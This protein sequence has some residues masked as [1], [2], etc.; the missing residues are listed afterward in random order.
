MQGE[1][2][3][4]LA[5]A[6]GSY[7]FHED[8]LKSALR[9]ANGLG[10][11][12][13]WQ[14][15]AEAVEKS[16]K[17]P[18]ATMASGPQLLVGN[19]MHRRLR[20]AENAFVYPVFY[21]Q[22]P[23]RDLDAGN[24]GIFSVDRANLLSLRQKDHGPRDGT[25]LLPWIQ[26][27]L[28]ERGLPDDGEITLQ[29]FPRVLGFVF[30]PVS[31]WFCRNTAGELI[32]VLA[33]V[34]NTFGGHHDYLL[35]NPDGS[36]LRDGQVL[37][38]GQ[39]VPRLAFLRRGRWL[40]L[41]FPCG[42]GPAAGLHRLRRRRGRPAADGDQRPARRLVEAGAARHL[43]AHAAADRRRHLAHPLA[44][45]EAVAEGRAVSWRAS[46]R[47]LP[48]PAGIDKMNNT[49]T[50]GGAAAPSRD[51]TPGLRAARRP[52]RRPARNPPAGRFQ[53]PVRR[54]R[55]GRHAACP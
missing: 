52:P 48:T 49:L 53:P 5:G 3:I 34:N 27:L 4:W 50:M 15:E 47:R 21:V 10:V 39:G 18:E 6:W 51:Y 14:G 55:A 19:V 41:P 24:V 9:V 22:L 13:P 37:Q 42:P 46:A 20:P 43:P 31:F 29:A 36:P 12:A 30:N 16:W 35:H 40:P 32:A 54:R 28:R 11:Q 2:G 25:P 33:E 23:L 7:G 8:G 1:R 44:G 45:P 17:R 38:G 26:S